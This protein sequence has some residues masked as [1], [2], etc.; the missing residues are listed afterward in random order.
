[1][2]R[3]IFDIIHLACRGAEVCHHICQRNQCSLIHGMGSVIPIYIPKEH[4][5]VFYWIDRSATL[6]VV[7]NAFRNLLCQGFP[8]ELKMT[9]K[10]IVAISLF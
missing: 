7:L 5:G 9:S 3:V 1:M 2:S 6:F 4:E 8:R 10:I